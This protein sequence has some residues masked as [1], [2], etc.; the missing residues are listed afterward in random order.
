MGSKFNMGIPTK[1]EGELSDCRQVFTFWDDFIS[2]STGAIDAATWLH[3]E[4]TGTVT[5]LEA[6]DA[7][8]EFA[9]GI[10]ALTTEA[11][12]TDICCMTLNGEHFMIDQGYPLYFEARFSITNTGYTGGFIGFTD[13]DVQENAFRVPDSPALGFK[14]N[15][16]AMDCVAVNAGGTNTDADLMTIADAIWYRVAIY[17][18]GDDTVTFYVATADGAF[19]PI[20]KMLLST[21]TDYVPQDL[22]MSI[23]FTN[24]CYVSGASTMY[25]DYVLAQQARCFAP[26]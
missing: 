19:V 17:Y 22:M 2:A 5:N 8:Q 6:T 14:P 15:G 4:T 21:T 26:E 25:V 18:D 10:M 24:E 11:T 20:D 12:S 3:T 13:F 7:S 23:N 9:G 16:D 1:F